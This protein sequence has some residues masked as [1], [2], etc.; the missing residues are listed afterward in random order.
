LS[1]FSKLYNDGFV[2]LDNPKAGDTAFGDS[3][4]TLSPPAE[5][6]GKRISWKVCNVI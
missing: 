5:K 1:L 3:E 6:Q 4:Q 2:I